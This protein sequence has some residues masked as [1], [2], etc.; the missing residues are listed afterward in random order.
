MDAAY[1]GPE[2]TRRVL[3]MHTSAVVDDEDVLWAEVSECRI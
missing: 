2:I 3:W 1:I